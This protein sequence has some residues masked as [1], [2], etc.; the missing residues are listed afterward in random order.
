[1][2]DGVGT[3]KSNGPKDKGF[4]GAPRVLHEQTEASE[5]AE[6]RALLGR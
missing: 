5:L 1:M 4:G 2:P 3:V 6:L